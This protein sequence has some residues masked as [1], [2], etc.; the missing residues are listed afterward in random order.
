M[1]IS[2]LGISCYYHDSS[3]ALLVNGEIKSAVQEERFSRIKNDS[4]FPLN[5]IKFILKENNL[6]LNEID[7]IVFYEKPF[8][9]FTR[10]L[11]TYLA[12]AP[13]GFNSFK[14]AI[15]IWIK[16]KLFQKREIQQE[17]KK[18]DKDF[19]G[20]I[21]F[22]EHH[23]SHAASAFYPSPFEE[24]LI[25][26]LDAVGEY[27]TSSIAIGKNNQINFKKKI[28]FPHSLGM[29]YSAFTYYCGFKVNEGEYKLMGLAPYGEPKYIEKI[30]KNLIHVFED[31]SFAL[32][33]KFFDYSTGLKMVNKKFEAVFGRKAKKKGD[34]FDQFHMDIAAS[35]QKVTEEIIL[36]ICSFYK[37]KYKLKKLC[38]AGGVALNCVANGKILEANIFDDIWIQPAAGDAGGSLGAALSIWFDKLNNK[39]VLKTNEDF[40]KGSFLGP[41]FS[42]EEIEKELKIFGANFRYLDEDTLLNTV[43]DLLVQ[44]KL[45]GWF[46]GAL[47]YGPR[48]LG[49]R[50]IIA[51][52][53]DMDMQKKIN[54]SIKFREGFRPFAP[55]VLS[56]ETYKYFKKNNLNSYMLIVSQIKDEFK[57]NSQELKK[58]KGF[59][60]LN[61]KR[62]FLQ[63]ITHVDYSARVQSIKK[64]QNLKFYNLI[65]KFHEKTNIPMVINTSFN[66]NNEPIVCSVEDAYRCFLV[67]DLDY[68]I[69]GNFLIEKN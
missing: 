42:D 1:T 31:G 17:L 34:K 33:M 24:A 12:N 62:S 16:E 45:I 64:E 36:K 13:F 27:T 35:V 66:I 39:R 67:T 4:S 5:S 54:M 47:E 18:I 48:A 15:P 43:S 69:C 3:A 38:L 20:K 52:P 32:N 51:H 30:Y 49:N 53:A 26:T 28:N 44:K 46:Q 56:E 37:E 50:S 41:K 23:L 21:L 11:E 22:S 29:L 19:D 57:E 63:A 59:E 58:Q 68:L 40:M 55:A 6:G 65:K 25:I 10:L 60:K 2:I 7:H 14:R 8:L 61:V 9:K